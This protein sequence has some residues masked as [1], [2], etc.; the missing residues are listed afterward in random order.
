MEI[1]NQIHDI[2]GITTTATILGH[3]QRGGSPTVRDR[4]A[5]S[6]MAVKATELLL[7][8]AA[9]RVIAVKH[10]EYVDYDIDEA[11]AMQKDVDEKMFEVSKLL[12]R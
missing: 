12:C 4:V 2:T 1:A 6:L 11:L 3:L 7:N 5:A 10:D 8:G 9:N